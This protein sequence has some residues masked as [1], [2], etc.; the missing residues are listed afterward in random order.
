MSIKRTAGFLVLAGV[1]LAGGVWV[2]RFNVKG[3][4]S[5]PFSVAET[6]VDVERVSA[7]SARA[8]TPV[9]LDSDAS[10][11][12][13]AE[14]PDKGF[15][16][17]DVLTALRHLQS[18][19]GTEGVRERIVDLIRQWAEHDVK[20]AAK[21]VQ[22]MPSGDAKTDAL[23]AVA[24]AFAEQDVKAGI[25][26]VWQLPEGEDRNHAIRSLSYEAARTEP[27]T[28]L[29]LAAGSLKPDQERD[30]LI[31]YAALQWAASD[32]EKAAGWADQIPDKVLRDNVL[33][34]V[35]TAWGESDPA[36]A[37]QFAV[38]KITPGTALNNAVV[39]IVQ[40]WVQK[41]RKT[42]AKWVATIHDE[43]LFHRATDCLGETGAEET[44]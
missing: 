18:Q 7:G 5:I 8:E 27:V 41:D 23:T 20:A 31:N 40:R 12:P 33:V 13:A 19:A 10:V 28:A 34:N 22:N 42:A 32:P 39:G 15:V 21:W 26:W 36:G 43:E 6:A 16:L 29:T 4:S 1:I 14:S 11:A 2:A 24:I 25:N 3:N 38:Q 17:S 9:S 44:P 37:A 30:D 35:T